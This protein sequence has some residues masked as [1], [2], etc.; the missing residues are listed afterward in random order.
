MQQHVE[1]TEF[2]R[3]TIHIGWSAHGSLLI[4]NGTLGVRE[5]ANADNHA[6]RRA[7]VAGLDCESVTTSGQAERR[8]Q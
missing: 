6:S 8:Q 7:G 4:D 2:V 1:G 5:S 3:Q